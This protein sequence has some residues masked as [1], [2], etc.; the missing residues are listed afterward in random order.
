[1][2][3]STLTVTN[4][5]DGPTPGSLRA[6]IAAANTG[7][8]I[9]FDPS[10]KG[11][12]ITLSDSQLE[13]NKSLTIQGPGAGQLTISGEPPGAD[14]I[15]SRLFQVDAN[16]NVT[17]SG[18]TM[19][20]GGG[21]AFA[22]GLS[23]SHVPAAWDGCGGGI[24]NLGTLTVSGCTL[25]GNSASGATHNCGGGICNNGT[26]T[27]SGCTLSSNS[28]TYNGTSFGGGIFNAG[29]L[30]VSSSTLSSNS[31]TLGGGIYNGSNP[32]FGGSSSFSATVTGCTLSANSATDG[33][34]I[35]NS[36]FGPLTLSGCTVS[37]NSATSA[38]GGIYNAKG[39]KLTIQSSVVLQNRAP[40]GADLDNLGSAK[41]S[42]DSTAGLI[43]T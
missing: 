35:F 7:D 10:L 43:A 15:N 12:T 24:L 25:S 8:T 34:G 2:L 5:L 29:T 13:I 33:G 37:G 18:L 36:Y 16:V 21:L 40:L 22:D 41:I 42:K 3:P 28:A 9:V 6:E 30:K 11:Q 26:L 20:L 19:T 27:V 31:A 17:L 4:N 23:S 1:L 14:A 38:G 32:S 39:G